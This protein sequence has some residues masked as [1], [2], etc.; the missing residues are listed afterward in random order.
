MKKIPS[1][2][3]MQAMK[4]KRIQDMG[5]SPRKEIGMMLFMMWM[6]GNELHIFSILIT[7]QALYAPLNNMMNVGKN[8][9]RF[10]KDA[11]SDPVLKSDLQS[12]KVMYVLHQLAFLALALVK[13]YYMG[14][15]P[16]DAVDWVDHEPYRF[17]ETSFGHLL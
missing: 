11:N 2:P 6:S 16:T 14:L 9:E 3:E 4:R 15:V 13:C 7:G 12:A 8:F 1:Q 17:A 5:S 10:E